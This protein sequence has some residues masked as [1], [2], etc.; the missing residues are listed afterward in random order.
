MLI[1]G[2]FPHLDTFGFTWLLLGAVVIDAL[3]GDPKGLYAHLPHPVVL[4]GRLVGWFDKAWNRETEPASARSGRG[5]LVA[6][7]VMALATLVGCL[8][9]W[10]CRVIPFGW[11][12]EVL[13]ISTLIAWRG[14]FDAVLNV[15]KGLEVNLKTGREAVSHIVGRDPTRLDEHGV[16]RAAIESGAENLSDGVVAPLF[17][18]LLFGLPGLAAYKAI[19]TLDSMIGHRTERHLAF[20]AFAARLDDVANW[21]PARVTG[22]LLVLAA[23]ILPGCSG[24]AA[25]RAMAKD[26]AN[27]RSPNAG[28]PEAAMAGALNLALGGPRTYKGESVNEAYMGSGT[29]EATATDIRSAAH[30]MAMAH[31]IVGLG[32]LALALV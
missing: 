12:L 23:C 3:I 19:N 16:A 25:L 29:P 6:L 2:L 24:L 26:A 22:L 9:T 11:G 5:A 18:A 20:G 27:H 28:F 17:W 8:L 7:L 14:L 4:I 15:A 13:L 21:L 1:S 32:L 30:L 10:L 31:L